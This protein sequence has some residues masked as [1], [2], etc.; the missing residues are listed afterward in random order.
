ME[1]VEIKLKEMRTNLG[2]TQ[3]ETADILGMAQPTWQK[4][5][6]GKVPDMR[7]ST[8]VHICKTMNVS[9]DWLLNLLEINTLDGVTHFYDKVIDLICDYGIE[10]FIADNKIDTIIN[11][12]NEIYSCFQD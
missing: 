4:L 10:G 8:L 5:E 3:V 12:I 9:A 6:S 1:V 7:V 2:L 11:D